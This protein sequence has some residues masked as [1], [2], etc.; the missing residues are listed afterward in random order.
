[1]NSMNR[2]NLMTTGKIRA[3]AACRPVPPPVDALTSGLSPGIFQSGESY[4][5][6]SG[7]NLMASHSIVRYFH[8]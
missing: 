2:G 5:P 6:K 7:E 3:G 1:M 4:W 8:W